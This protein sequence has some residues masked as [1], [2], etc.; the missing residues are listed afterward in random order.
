MASWQEKIAEHESHASQ[1]GTPM[2]DAA[3][4]RSS[5][6]Q[7]MVNMIKTLKEACVIGFTSL[8][9]MKS[10]VDGFGEA[11][12]AEVAAMKSKLTSQYRPDVTIGNR[13]DMVAN[14]LETI[15][16]INTGE[17]V[18]R[19]EFIAEIF[20]KPARSINFIT[21]QFIATRT[22]VSFDEVAGG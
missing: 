14:R 11:V 4:T 10:V 9:N 21:L 2:S 15:R 16:P 22:G 18:D 8:D 6:I 19:N 1:T 17:V 20:V 3:R 5:N 13:M 12:K 7:I